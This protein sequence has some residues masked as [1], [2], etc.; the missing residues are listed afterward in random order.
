[1]ARI[2]VVYKGGKR[3]APV[4]FVR[5]RGKLRERVGSAEPFGFFTTFLPPSIRRYYGGPGD[6]AKGTPA[7]AVIAYDKNGHVLSR[8]KHRN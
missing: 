2:R 3:D 4:R 8:F 6:R 7:I 5:V 1:M